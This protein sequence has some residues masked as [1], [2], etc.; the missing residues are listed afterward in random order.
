MIYD[1][2]TLRRA[3]AKPGDRIW[4]VAYALN[5][6]KTKAGQCVR[7][8]FGELS[9]VGKACSINTHDRTK[10]TPV[11]YFV[12]HGKNGT[13]VFSKAVKLYTRMY[14]DTEHEAAV[15]FDMLVRQ[16][17]AE[18]RRTADALEQDL[19]GM[20]VHD[21]AMMDD[22]AVHVLP[23]LKFKD[24]NGSSEY[25]PYMVYKSRTVENAAIDD[26]AKTITFET[27]DGKFAF[28]FNFIA[29]LP[30]AYVF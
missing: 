28:P 22:F 9:D 11:N 15:L 3:G 4:A 2:I 27:P 10:K 23:Y 5:K 6:E 12:P 17:A 14:A 25:R 30:D 8:V 20:A 13:P 19:L 29:A 26:S 21:G 1:F 24:N 18:L 16:E 7:P